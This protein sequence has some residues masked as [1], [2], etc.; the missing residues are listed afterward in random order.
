ME[1][2]AKGKW[3]FPGKQER[4]FYGELKFSQSEDDALL[5]SDTIDRLWDFPRDKQDFLLLG[6]LTDDNKTLN[7]SVIISLMTRYQEKIDSEGSNV[8]VNLK[9]RFV[10]LGIHIEDPNHIEF[11]KVFLNFS[12]I[13]H[14]I[15][16]IHDLIPEPSNGRAYHSPWISIHQEC[17]IQVTSLT[18]TYK[19]GSK[20]VRENNIQFTVESLGDRSLDNY[21]NLEGKVRDF[22][23]FVI[24]KGVVLQSFQGLYRKGSNSTPFTLLFHSSITEKMHKVTIKSP[25]LLS[26]VDVSHQFED[27]LKRWF[28]LYAENKIIMDLY[29]GVIYN[30]QSYL[31]NSF[32]MIFTALE[33]SCCFS[34]K[35]Q[36]KE[37][38]KGIFWQ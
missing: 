2:F 22:L 4:Q 16:P 13:D 27:I 14:W 11:D 25:Y 38:R 30:T 34:G 35:T 19:E 28:K 1:K 26:Y 12:N 36:R 3:W 32:L 29:F 20:R 15:S 9:P 21:L 6:N 24:N 7:V 10:F 8:T 5:L 33:A 23:N 31:L 37:K 17:R 18:K